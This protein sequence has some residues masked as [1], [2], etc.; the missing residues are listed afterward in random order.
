[1][2]FARLPHSQGRTAGALVIVVAA[3]LG[4]TGLAVCLWTWNAP[5]TLFQELIKKEGVVI[6]ADAGISPVTLMRASYTIIAAG[7]MVLGIVLL[8]LALFVR[9]GGKASAVGAIVIISLILLFLL[10]QFVGVF[11][12]GN[13]ADMIFGIL[14]I[15]A[16]GALCVATI[17]KLLAAYQAGAAADT[18]AMQAHC[19][20]MQQQQQPAG[21]GYGY[22][23]PAPPL[24]AEPISFVPPASQ[25][26]PPPRDLPSN[27]SP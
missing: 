10:L 12:L 1:M 8:I 26:P 5:D 2:R 9:R 11:M 7:A 15:G 25:L 4:L 27:S 23:Y 21:Y 18:S 6:P 22:G 13:G 20:M 3:L 24:G 19:W 14:L 16:I 17:R